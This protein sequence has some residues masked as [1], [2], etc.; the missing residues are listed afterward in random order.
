MPE[1]G[2]LR[3]A[4][5]MEVLYATGLRVSELVGLPLS[6]LSRDGRVLIVRGKGGRERTLPLTDP[7]HQCLGRH[8]R[9]LRQQEGEGAAPRGC[10]RRAR[11]AA[12]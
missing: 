4:A 6:A 7:G 11:K 1:P 8:R 10:S 5:L 12:T 9:W 3:L 2:G